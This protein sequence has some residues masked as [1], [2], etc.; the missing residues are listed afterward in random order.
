MK[1]EVVGK[2]EAKLAFVKWIKEVT[3][4]GLKDSKDLADKMFET[5]KPLVLEVSNYN[6]ALETFTASC[7]SPTFKLRKFRVDFIQNFLRENDPEL[8]V[9]SDVDYE[10]YLRLFDLLFKNNKSNLRTM[11]NTGVDD[12][13]EH[14]NQLKIQ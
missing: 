4:F 6:H 2:T 3:G 7:A 11:L 1:I 13:K 5:K 14:L 9:H 12:L 10:E 8:D